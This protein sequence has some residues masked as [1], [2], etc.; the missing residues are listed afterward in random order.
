MIAMVL[1]FNILLLNLVIAML[2]NTYSVFDDRSTGLFLSKIL[3]SRDELMW[4]N[5]YG[6]YLTS[7]PPLNCIQ[8]PF[9]I[10]AMFLRYKSALVE[11]INDYVMRL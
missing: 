7:M 8:I 10:P 11:M 9:V 2:A 6:A 3:V 4:D 5:S 1:A